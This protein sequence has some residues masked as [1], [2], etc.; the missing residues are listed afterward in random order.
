MANEL[1]HVTLIGTIRSFKINNGH[2]TQQ[3]KQN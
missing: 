1:G 2:V 3:G